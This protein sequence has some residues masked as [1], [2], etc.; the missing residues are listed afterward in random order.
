MCVGENGKNNAEPTLSQPV[1]A[2]TTGAFVG[3]NFAIAP[4]LP[5]NHDPPALASEAETQAPYRGGPLC[6]VCNWVAE[7]QEMSKSDAKH[8][9]ALEDKLRI[10]IDP[11]FF[12]PEQDFR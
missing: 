7:G 10:E 3:R 2:R 6:A 12:E 11:A 8:L 1:K 4:P 9:Q 5:L